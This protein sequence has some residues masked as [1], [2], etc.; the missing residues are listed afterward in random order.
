VDKRTT[1]GR[2]KRKVGSGETRFIYDLLELN[3]NRVCKVFVLV[4]F[5]FRALCA[6]QR[7]EESIRTAKY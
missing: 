4:L 2:E 3:S 7:G 1:R 5:N 6:C